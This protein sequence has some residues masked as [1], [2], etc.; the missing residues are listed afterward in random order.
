MINQMTVNQLQ[1]FFRLTQITISN[2]GNIQIVNLES[3]W[4]NLIEDLT[5]TEDTL[6]RLS[7]LYQ[8]RFWHP[9]LILCSQRL[10]EQNLPN[11][12]LELDPW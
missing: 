9:T 7:N 10:V 12:S 3:N 2:D 8:Q 4:V 1:F 11:H 6:L 5:K